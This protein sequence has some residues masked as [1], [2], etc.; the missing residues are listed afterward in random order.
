MKNIEYINILETCDKISINRDE[1]KTFEM[2]VQF[3]DSIGISL[4][5]WIHEYLNLD[6]FDACKF[7]MKLYK[8]R[9]NTYNDKEYI[10][11][12]DKIKS[13]A[14]T[15]KNVLYTESVLL[16][17]NELIDAIAESNT[18]DKE[19]VYKIVEMGRLIIINKKQFNV[20]INNKSV[21]IHKDM[22]HGFYIGDNK[23]NFVLVKGKDIILAPFKREW[24]NKKEY[25][26]DKL[27]KEG[28]DLVLME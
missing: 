23:Y 22:I 8:L 19:E 21:S 11:L 25:V 16:Y 13:V 27:F 9:E 17:N 10:Q 12:L 18:Y 1:R 28:Y 20:K 26:E 24:D 2:K 7:I 4:K 14:G 15:Y 5:E 3:F 6:D